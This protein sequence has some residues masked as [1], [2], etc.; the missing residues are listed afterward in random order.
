MGRIG[1][2]K[3]VFGEILSSKGLLSDGTHT[4]FEH[5]KPQSLVGR[6]PGLWLFMIKNYAP[7]LL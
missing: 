7:N 5:K 4:N 6:L 3:K 1:I 2:N